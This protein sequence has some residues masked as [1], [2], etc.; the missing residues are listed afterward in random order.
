MDLVLLQRRGPLAVLAAAASALLLVACGNAAPASPSTSAQIKKDWIA[1]FSA[2][3][4]TSRR[5]ALLE[6]GTQFRSEIAALSSMASNL[7]STVQK[8]DVT[9]ASTATV[10]YTLE[11]GGAPIISGQKGQAVKEGLTWKVGDATLCGLLALEGQRPSACSSVSGATGA[12]GATGSS[13]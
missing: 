6:N 7:S 5:L 9:S 10:T 2:S 3:T 11:L 8:V 13:G 4:S 12:T 1:F